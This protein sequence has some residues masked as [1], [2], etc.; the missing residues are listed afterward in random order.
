MKKIYDIRGEFNRGEKGEHERLTIAKYSQVPVGCLFIS[1]SQFR[2]TSRWV[3]V[4]RKRPFEVAKKGKI[5]A[6]WYTRGW[7]GT[8]EAA[9]K[10]AEKMAKEGE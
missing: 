8:L 4:D 10:A 5:G 7:F 1:Y 9:V 6:G 3:H 2:D